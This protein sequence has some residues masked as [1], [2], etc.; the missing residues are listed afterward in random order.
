MPGPRSYQGRGRDHSPAPSAASTST[1]NP[2]REPYVASGARWR[3]E[4]EARRREE[5][6]R[7]RERRGDEHSRERDR[8]RDEDR[9]RD[10]D[11]RRD[12]GRG[13]RSP[14]RVRRPSTSTR[15]SDSRSHPEPGPSTSEPSPQKKEL[16]PEEKRSLWLN[17][18]DL[19]SQAVRARSE[20]LRLKEDLQKYERLTRSAHFDALPEEERTALQDLVSSSLSKVQEKQQQLNRFAAQLVPEDFWPSNLT[21]QQQSNPEFKL[22]NS[23]LAT[24][25]NDVEKLQS[26]LQAAQKSA[27]TATVTEDDASAA[28]KSQPGE[29]NTRRPKKRR[30]LSNE[31]TPAMVDIPAEELEKTQDR[32]LAL[33]SRIVELR[34]DL[35]QYDKRVEDEVESQLSD[36]LT[37]LRIESGGKE[38]Q[39]ADPELQKRVAELASAFTSTQARAA[40]A[41]KELEQLQAY[42]DGLDKKNADLQ[43]QN[44]SLRKQLEEL[45]T[46][47]SN[48]SKTL[49]EQKKE[50]RA[51]HDAVTAYLSRPPN[52]PVP[53]TP[54][55]ADAMVETLRPRL[56][57][58]AREDLLPTLQ[59]LRAQVQQQL[60]TQSD[61]VS[62]DLMSQMG[63]IIRAVEWISAW[64]E[65]IRGPTGAV[66]TSTSSTA[67]G[68]SS[69]DKGK[70]VAR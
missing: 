61:Q 22:M 9:Y 59:E 35:L 66:T 41:A 51:L 16:T 36:R 57:S 39:P 33:D 5:Q 13:S 53:P 55:T 12:R 63:P 34:N 30:R 19:L 8:R 67:G 38:N 46:T 4:E 11:Y 64:L 62:G 10:E 3:E 20:L 58:A 18:V 65:R 49:E 15:P 69:V 47:Q 68:S 56:F 1:A 7:D 70:G 44:E 54:L 17:R 43:Q 40:E 2:R 31:G 6:R 27:A 52:P 32:L 14:S 45:E 24:L 29:S 28:S 26:S 60:Q 50:L 25:H 21:A 48:T 23:A 42:G 37:G